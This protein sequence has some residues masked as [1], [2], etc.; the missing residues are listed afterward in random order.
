MHFPVH[1]KIS[2][3]TTVLSLQF[4][5]TNIILIIYIVCVYVYVYVYINLTLFL[6]DAPTVTAIDGSLSNSVVHSKPS[7][8]Q[9]NYDCT[10]FYSF[11]PHFL[12]ILCKYSHFHLFL[13][14]FFLVAVFS[15]I[16]A[17][18]KISEQF[19]GFVWCFIDPL[20]CLRTPFGY[21]FLW[22]KSMVMFD[23]V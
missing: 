4:V 9:L 19:R 21:I 17:R 5:S 13:F 15:W 2:G 8:N 14:L 16:L 23:C 7:S 20:L 3:Q 1:C 11:T 10:L 18:I 6:I 22:L 12:H